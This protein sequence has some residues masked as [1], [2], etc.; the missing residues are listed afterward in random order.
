MASPTKEELPKVP[1][2]FKNELEKFDSAKMK[3]AETKEKNPLPSKE[4]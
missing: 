1:S 3:H 4:G 2:D